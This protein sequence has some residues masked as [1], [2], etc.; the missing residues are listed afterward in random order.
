MYAR[1]MV[2]RTNRDD[3]LATNPIRP[4]VIKMMPLPIYEWPIYNAALR[5]EEGL[6]ESLC[7]CWTI[8]Q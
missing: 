7:L 8:R 2:T 3:I 5:S 4:H 6:G 1:Q